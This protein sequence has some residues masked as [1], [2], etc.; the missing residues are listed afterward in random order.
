M[1][2]ILAFTVPFL[3]A[4]LAAG[5]GTPAPVSGVPAS[6]FDTP[7]APSASLAGTSRRTRACAP[8]DTL[9]AAP[10]PRGGYGRLVLHPP[11]TALDA[12]EPGGRVDVTYP[13]S[14]FGL[15]LDREGRLIRRLRV[16]I[17][18]SWRS[19][20]GRLV[21]WVAPPSLDPVVRLGQLG[22]DG[23]VVGEVTFNKFLVFVTR[24]PPGAD[25]R[26][27]WRGPVVLKATSHSGRMRSMA[28][29]GTLEPEPC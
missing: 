21:A 8:V 17:D 19:G 6:L 13:S 3:A 22:A 28:S 1:H 27:R 7:E 4:P 18:A 20:G 15:P 9:D 24:E 23:S 12:R 2:R 29:H 5:P 11:A 10:E 25:D 16:E 14:P 26:T